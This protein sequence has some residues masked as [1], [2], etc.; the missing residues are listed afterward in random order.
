MSP[1][2]PPRLAAWLLDRLTSGPKRESL[3][4]DLAEQYRHDRST[5]WYW[6]QVLTAILVGAASDV[7]VHQR[8]A[9]RAVLITWVMVIPWAKSTLALYLWV[10]ERWVNAWVPSSGVFFEFWH[11]LGGGLPLVW[12]A[13]SAV[14]GWVSARWSAH[15]R[16][17]MVIVSTLAV[18]PLTLWWAWPGLTMLHV[19]RPLRFNLP[20]G[21][22]AAI[23]LVGIPLS[24]LLGGLW[25]SSEV[26]SDSVAARPPSPGGI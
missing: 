26:D 8:L 2:S 18:M 25:G 22:W 11:P 6:R 9:V 10:S 5:G 12:C 16:P 20:N 23:V 14:S 7:R 15:H 21:I 4:G 17:A 24:I 13:G 19:G 3:I 1:T